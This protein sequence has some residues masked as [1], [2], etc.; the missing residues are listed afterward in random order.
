VEIPENIIGIAKCFNPKC[1]TNNETMIT[2]F[3]LVES[4]PLALKCMYCEKIT[5]EEH[6]EVL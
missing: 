1:V 3:A 4:E 2:K 6:L 5:N